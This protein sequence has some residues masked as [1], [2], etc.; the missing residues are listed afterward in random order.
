MP[1]DS[2]PNRRR[3]HRGVFVQA[4][5]LLIRPWRHPRPASERT[6]TTAR[7]R[8]AQR[9]GNADAIW[10]DAVEMAALLTREQGK[11]IREQRGEVAGS[12]DTCEWLAE[13]GMRLYGS[14]VA[15]RAGRSGCAWRAACR[16]R[17]SGRCSV[18]R[19][20]GRDRDRRRGH[21]A[22]RPS[23]RG[24]PVSRP[25]SMGLPPQS[26][27]VRALPVG[28]AAFRVN[29]DAGAAAAAASALPSTRD[30]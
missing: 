10:R 1:A 9:L 19:P 11:T 14:V 18:C 28:L 2:V 26:G 27:A 20:F 3:Q 17:R 25:A 5:T 30:R 7:I 15:A 12:A 24:E 29:A 16:P 21:R 6:A 22:H 4:W 8:E 23:G 13:E